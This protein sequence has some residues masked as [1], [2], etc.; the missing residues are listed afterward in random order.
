MGFF[1]DLEARIS[2]LA[3]AIAAD[4]K[5]TGDVVIAVN[6][7]LQGQIDGKVDYDHEIQSSNSFGGRRLYQT[8]LDNM[9]HR[10]DQ[11][12]NVSGVIRNATTNALVSTLTTAQVASLFDTNYDS[13]II[14]AAGN[15]LVVTID[16]SPTTYFLNGGYPYGDFIISHYHTYKSESASVRVYSAYA[17]QGG[18]G[19]FT[20]PAPEDISNST[21]YRTWRTRNS[22][23]QVTTAEFTVVAGAAEA[24]VTQIEHAPE[25]PGPVE[26]AVVDKYRAN[27]LYDALLWAKDR[28]VN[29]RVDETGAGVFTSVKV[30]PAAGMKSDVLLEGDDRLFTAWG[31]GGMTLAS[32][33]VNSTT[34]P[35]TSGAFKWGRVVV[36]QFKV[37]NGNAS[38]SIVTVGNISAMFRPSVR[39]LGTALIGTS[40]AGGGT[41]TTF[42]VETNGNVV[43]V[44]GVPAGSYITGSLTF[45]APDLTGA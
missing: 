26:K 10:A 43:S 1:S 15:K 6:D 21:S 16:F 2:A 23:F 27:T 13:R 28:V 20:L 29:A 4:M 30:G 3:S 40:A 42:H 35:I 34:T 7:A 39:A 38:G 36:L 45:F 14:I 12:W 24:N 22:Y 9:L 32:G 31:D 8:E 19:W 41:P 44:S 37:R 25:R 17:P 18:P 33:V 5:Q 11:R